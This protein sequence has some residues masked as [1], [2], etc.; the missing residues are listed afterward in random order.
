MP[1][2]APLILAA[3]AATAC[4]QD[5]PPPPGD[6][7]TTFDT[8]G[9]VVHASNVGAAPPAR[10]ALVVSIGP[11]TFAQ[12][13]SPDEFGSVNSVA[14]GPDEEVFVADGMNREIRVFGLDGAHRRSFGREGE[15]P[16]EFGVI[17]SLSWVGDR[18]LALDGHLGRVSEFSPQ[19]DV[20]GQRRSQG[21]LSGA[22]AAIRFYSVGPDEAYQ[23][24]IGTG[25]ENTFVGHHSRGLTGDTLRRMA[26][27]PLPPNFVICE[28]DGGT[29][30]FP[31]PFGAGH[32]Q[33]PA[34]AAS[35]TRR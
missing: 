23:F 9:G 30:V 24:A 17:H 33:T 12:T 16:G 3:A 11:K 14:L 2:V 35:C 34:P 22:P 4:G 10:L 31:I 1:R 18:L 21:G 28:Y 26:S 7:T 20:L 13:E 19:G 5:T 29:G 6:L 8:I 25:R 15:G 27:P 32:F